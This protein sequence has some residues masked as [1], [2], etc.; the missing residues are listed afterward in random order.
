MFV[1]N[2]PMS[3]WVNGTLG[4]ITKLDHKEKEVTVQIFDGEEVVVTPHTRKISQYIYDKQKRSLGTEV[5]GTFTQI[6][7]MLSRAITIHKSQGKTYQN[8]IID[9]K[10]I[11]AKGQ[12]YVALSRCTTLEGIKLINPIQ[13]NHVM[14]DYK[15][16]KFLTNVQ[17]QKAHD[18][19]SIKDTVLLIQEA[20]DTNKDIKITYLKSSD[21][22]SRRTVT[23]LEVG[24]QTYKDI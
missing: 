4:Y 13:K 5:L 17:Y 1:A 8:V 20:I 19:I 16:V 23:P 24:E 18:Q 12:L 14:I 7:L 22:K 15:I 3:K 21:I 2:D 10:G 6:P 9:P 11:F